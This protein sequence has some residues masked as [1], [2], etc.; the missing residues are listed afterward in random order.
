MTSTIPV[1]ERARENVEDDA[2]GPV[3]PD[4]RVTISG[5]PGMIAA[6]DLPSPTTIAC[7][8]PP[9]DVGKGLGH[10]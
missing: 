5:D 9:T 10:G 7:R 1:R 6:H 3:A 8:Q 2:F 4:V